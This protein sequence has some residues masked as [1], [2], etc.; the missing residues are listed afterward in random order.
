MRR[1]SVTNFIRI[2]EQIST[3]DSDVNYVQIFAQKVRKSALLVA[4]ILFARKKLSKLLRCQFVN[5]DN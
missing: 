1:I 5:K 3:Q 4:L 2:S